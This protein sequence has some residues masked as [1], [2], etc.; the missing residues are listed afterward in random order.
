ML[1]CNPESEFCVLLARGLDERNNVSV[2]SDD[3]QMTD[4]PTLSSA[5]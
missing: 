3:A 5:W 1:L 4:Q 2:F